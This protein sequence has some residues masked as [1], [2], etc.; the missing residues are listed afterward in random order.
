MRKIIKLVLIVIIGIA[1]GFTLLLI[2]FLLP[3]GTMKEHLRESLD[4]IESEFVSSEV[5][6]G[7]D[8]TLTGS[9]TDNLMLAHAVYDGGEHSLLE[10]T[11]IMYRGESSE[12]TSSEV[13]GWAPGQS[14]YDYLTGMGQIREVEYARYWHGYLILLK[15]LLMLVNYNTI[16]MLQ[17]ILQPLL[18]G[19]FLYMCIRKEKAELGFG[20]VITTFFLYPFS[21]YFSLSLSICF[22]VMI[23]ALLI[24]IKWHDEIKTNHLYLEFFLIIGI[25]TAYFDFLTYPLVTLGMPLCLY[26]Y[27]EHNEWKEK[28]ASLVKYAIAWAGGYLGMWAGKWVITDILLNQRVIGDAL[29][30]LQTRTD[31][32]GSSLITGFLTVLQKNID[33]YA[34]W[35]Y[36]I[37]LMGILIFLF[38]WLRRNAGKI[39]IKAALLQGIPYLAA[40]MLPILWI[41]FTQNHSGEH[42]MFTCK[43]IS[44]TI[45]AFILYI[46]SLGKTGAEA[47]TK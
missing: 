7:Y 13:D 17:A 40:A 47:E 5:V 44:I 29:S 31:T 33:P 28:L 27:L 15:P 16:R 20:M 34:N 1:A 11:L 21:M 14:L 35:T 36:F 10:Q 18:M 39:T 30:A 26:L 42:Y 22:Y 8:A 6:K 25:V 23:I 24:Q 41:F 38:I 2:S 37:L 9:F 45:F 12:I 43:I 4:L 46:L 19:L 3:T 32:A